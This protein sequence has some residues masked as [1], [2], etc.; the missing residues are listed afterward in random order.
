MRRLGH[1][2]HARVPGK[3]WTTPCIAGIKAM[4]TTRARFACAARVEGP[5]FFQELARAF[6]FAA[7]ALK[8]S[9]SPRPWP[10]GPA[11]R[12]SRSSQPRDPR[13]NTS[14][15]CAARSGV[16]PISP[17]KLGNG[18]RADGISTAARVRV[19]L[20][21][22]PRAAVDIPA[23]VSARSEIHRTYAAKD[24]RGAA[25]QTPATRGSRPPLTDGDNLGTRWARQGSR[26]S[27]RVARYRGVRPLSAPAL[28]LNLL[29][30]L[31]ADSAGS[32]GRCRI[33]YR[34][35]CFLWNLAHREVRSEPVVSSSVPQIPSQP[36]G[37]R[38]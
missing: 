22:R 6:V 14:E 33:A 25:R 7:S 31:V 5:G 3:D 21:R 15:H 1:R 10:I 4:Q 9:A 30:R 37:P 26:R 28:S 32:P 19:R 11:D 24:F 34:P 18:Q 12:A 2:R 8:N 13:Y 17:G 36:N 27:V 38:D 16:E 29:S 35:E 20:D 23:R